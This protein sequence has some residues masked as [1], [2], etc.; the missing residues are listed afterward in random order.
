MAVGAPCR[1]CQIPMGSVTGV[2]GSVRVGQLVVFALW[3]LMTVGMGAVLFA[4]A[5][6]RHVEGATAVGPA[7]HRPGH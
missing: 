6:R 7:G 4:I 1:R 2:A 5:R 3:L